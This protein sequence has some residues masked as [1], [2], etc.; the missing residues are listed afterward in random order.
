MN[1]VLQTILRTMVWGSVGLFVSGVQAQ[2]FPHKPVKIVVP[3]PA[4]GVVDLAAR[5]LANRLQTVWSQPVVVE[6]K[7]GAG[8]AI[9]AEQVA[10]ATPDGYT[11]LVTSSALTMNAALDPQKST[12]TSKEL[13]RV[14]LLCHAPGVLIV[15]PSGAANL[16]ELIANARANPGKL[17][18]ATSGTGSPAHFATELFKMQQNIFALHIPYTGAPAAM[19]DQIAGRIDFQITNATVALPQITPGRVRALAVTSTTRMPLLP[20]VP[21]LMESGVAN[22]NADQWIGLFTPRGTP[23][24]I[25]EKLSQE[26]NKILTQDAFR[27]ALAKSGINTAVPGSPIEFDKFYKQD[28][29]KWTRV[30]KAANIK[31]E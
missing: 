4:G 16:K 19:T 12:E 8:G 21:T 20:D 10:R 18:Y 5:Q 2:G 25:T 30:V 26:V 23:A 29:V 13:E 9:G 28:I 14:A 22:Y 11:L 15:H 24:N 6:N 17:S 7:V 3:W 1:P 27:Q 31:P